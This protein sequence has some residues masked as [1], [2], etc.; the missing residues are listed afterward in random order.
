MSRAPVQLL[1]LA[2]E[3]AEFT[4]AIRSELERLRDAQTI[5]VLDAVVVAKDA[6]GSVRTLEAGSE[7]GHLLLRLLDGGGGD[8]A[9]LDADNAAQLA[10]AAGSIPPG[11]AAAL[12]LI[13]HVWA[14]GLRDA[15]NAA[16]GRTVAETWVDEGDLGAVGLA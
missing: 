11:S 10:D 13:E 12:L 1:V 6:D 2:F 8:A 3:G 16:G 4:G 7:D 14:A 5:Q 9:T 15:V